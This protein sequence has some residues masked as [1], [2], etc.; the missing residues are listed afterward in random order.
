MPQP[1]LPVVTGAFSYTS[2]YRKGCRPAIEAWLIP[3]GDPLGGHK[4]A[5][6]HPHPRCFGA[7]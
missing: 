7:A 6:P 2:R 1:D 3:G 4:A 5:A